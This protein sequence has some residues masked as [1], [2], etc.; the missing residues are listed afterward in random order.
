[1][2]KIISISPYFPPRLGGGEQRARDLS[3]HLAKKG[4]Q[5]EV[6]TSDID[7]PK[8][9]QLKSTKNL[10][11]HYL[12]AREFAHTPII[13][14]LFS[15]L[16]NIPKDSIID[17]NAG[18]ALSPEIGLLISK[19][20]SI[21]Y[22]VHFRADPPISGS[23]GFL[24]KTYKKLFLSKVLKNANRIIALNKDYKNLISKRYI[25]SKNKIIVIPNATDFRIIKENKLRIRKLKCLLFVGRFT[26]EKN[27]TS[28]IE[29]LS[30]LKNKDLRFFLAGDGEDKQK[31]ITL[32]KEL[33]L[34][35]QVI[36]LGELN[37]KKLY[38]EYLKS[39]L[40]ILP[41]KVECFSSVLLEAM[42]TGVPIIASD[43]PGTRSVI[44]D[45]YNGILVEPTPEKIAEAIDKLIK[46]PKLREKLAR[47]GLK[48]VKKY[49]WDKIVEQTEK[50]YEEVLRE[51][52]KKQKK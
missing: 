31:L 5:V 36:F 14:S 30:L 12:P 8:N 2:K 46:N 1:M 38:K 41:S 39:D 4:H 34:K 23:W 20:R 24:L 33:G 42:A 13:P 52:N 3:E 48:E 10:K 18:I 35:K 47:N 50:V 17:I 27:I 25:L 44:K 9:K 51:H 32:I 15:K 29:A 22:I 7:C 40:V 37:R 43:I 45:N 11:I 6:F 49:S 16:M 28:I 21:P 19:L 26:S